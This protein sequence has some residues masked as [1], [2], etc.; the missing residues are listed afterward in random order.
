MFLA[1]VLLSF[2]FMENVRIKGSL[3]N[4]EGLNKKQNY[5]QIKLFEQE[6]F[7]VETV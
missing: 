3:A 6:G 2:L 4:E 1:T 7:R 5:E